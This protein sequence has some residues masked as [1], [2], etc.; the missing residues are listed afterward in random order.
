MGTP[1][2]SCVAAAILTAAACLT[3]AHHPAAQSALAQLG[4]TEAAVRNFVLDEIKGAALERRS[5]IAIAG[6]ARAATRSS[7]TSAR[8]V[9]R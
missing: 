3:L 2:P 4:L 9:P 6:A 1:G 8:W 7:A 5:P